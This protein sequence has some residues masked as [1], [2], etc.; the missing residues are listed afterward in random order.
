M[1]LE[2]FR[3]EKELNNLKLDE[4]KQYSSSQHSSR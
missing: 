3:L 2:Q 1:K 4:M